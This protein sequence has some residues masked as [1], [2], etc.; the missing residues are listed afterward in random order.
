MIYPL[1]YNFRFPSLFPIFCQKSYIFRNSILRGR[2][3][4]YKK[5][6]YVLQYYLLYYDLFLLRP[7]LHAIRSLIKT[8]VRTIYYVKNSGIRHIRTFFLELILSSIIRACIYS[9]LGQILGR[10]CGFGFL[11]FYF[12]LKSLMLMF[13]FYYLPPRGSK[14]CE[15]DQTLTL[16]YIRFKTVL[17]QYVVYNKM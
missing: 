5:Y 9:S 11:T 17:L 10:F 12:N 16:Q 1:C 7:I 3:T 15:F 14:N 4:K 8:V 2:S 6:L 13:G